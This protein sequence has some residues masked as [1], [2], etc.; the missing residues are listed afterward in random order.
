M[1]G[2]ECL[3]SSLATAPSATRGV[4][5]LQA[6]YTCSSFL[7]APGYHNVCLCSTSALAFGSACSSSNIASACRVCLSRLLVAD[8]SN[9]FF[10]E[11]CRCIRLGTLARMATRS[12]VTPLPA[13]YTLVCYLK[14]LLRPPGLGW[15][16]VHAGY[17][18]HRQRPLAVR[19]AE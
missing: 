11:R 15:R 13:S 7:F 9:P 16:H 1:C 3:L 17:R 14:L 5:H 4:Q 12:Y 10:S 8:V 6:Y 19:C 2:L 18:K